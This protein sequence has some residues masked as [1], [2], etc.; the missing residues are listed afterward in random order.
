MALLIRIKYR[1]LNEAA[2]KI[3]WPP[4]WSNVHIHISAMRQ[5]EGDI[6]NALRMPHIGRAVR[7]K[8]CF[9]TN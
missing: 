1:V 4:K 6:F 8:I 5:L 7:E 9:E 2:D 3:S